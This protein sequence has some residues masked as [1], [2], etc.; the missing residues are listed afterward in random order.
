[1]KFYRYDAVS[2]VNPDSDDNYFGFSY[3]KLVLLEFYLVKETPYFYR[4]AY[5]WDK[6]LSCTKLVGKKTKKKF[7]HT[8]KEAAA[9]A[10]FFRKKRQVGILE[11]QLKRAKSAL[12][13]AENLKLGFVE[14]DEIKK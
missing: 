3:Q 7:A 5:D 10:F 9:E 6:S 12:N 1:M 4:V 14:E 13:M 8:T 11:E 2:Y